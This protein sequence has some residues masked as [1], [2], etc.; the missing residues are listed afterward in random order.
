MS[1]RNHADMVPAP[2][3]SR[4]IFSFSLTASR[5]TEVRRVVFLLD[6]ILRVVSSLDV[7]PRTLRFS[8]SEGVLLAPQKRLS[9]SDC[10]SNLEP[11]A[12]SLLPPMVVVE[13]W[14]ENGTE[15]ASSSTEVSKRHRLRR[16]TA[17][18]SSTEEALPS[19]ERFAETSSTEERS[20]SARRISQRHR[21]QRDSQRRRLQRGERRRWRRIISSDIVYGEKLQRRRLQK[22]RK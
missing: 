6:P 7:C 14:Q 4:G 17:V 2:G 8:D 22:K 20:T 3:S 11:R 10:W 19:T 12:I 1:S 21:L 15:E 13:R 18:T 5:A 9:S 16:R